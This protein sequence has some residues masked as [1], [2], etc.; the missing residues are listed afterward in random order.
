MNIAII[1]GLDRGD[2]HYTA[3]AQLE[4]H[5][6]QRHTGDMAGRGNEALAALVERSQLVIV[7]TDVNSHA[8]VIGARRVA[9]SHRKRCVLVR[10]FGLSRFRAL[11][12]DLRS[13]ACITQK[14]SGI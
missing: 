14:A 6:I 11:L 3:L 8:A 5:S 1:G 9:R 10:R 4:G 2:H 13:D 7:I 12:N